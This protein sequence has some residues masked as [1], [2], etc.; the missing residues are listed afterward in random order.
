MPR[1]W[2]YC[3]I[4]D[5]P[6]NYKIGSMKECADKGQ[7]RRYGMYKLDPKILLGALGIKNQ[8]D[9]EKEK[10]KLEASLAGARG[11][12][13]RFAKF[14]KAETESDNSN[15]KKVKELQAKLDEAKEKKDTIL[16][17]LKEI[18]KKIEQSKKMSRQKSVKKSVKKSIKRSGSIRKSKSLK[19]SGS[20]KKSKSLKRSKKSKKMSKRS[21]SIKRPKS[22]KR[23][24]SIKR[25]SA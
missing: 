6:T 2:T 1:K 19:R 18:K 21:K 16:N 9:L 13:S 22:V 24:K 12:V 17:K 3:G 25:L 20:I 4:G 5:V 15:A 23:S 14:L 7:V 8:K 11:K 10:N